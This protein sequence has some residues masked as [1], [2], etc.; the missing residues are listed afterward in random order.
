MVVTAIGLALAL[1]ATGCRGDDKAAAK[2]TWKVDGRPSAVAVARGTVW[3]ADDGDDVVRRYDAEDG[4]T[5]GRAIPVPANPVAIAAR[6]DDAWVASAG[7]EVTHLRG[8]AV[9]GSP[10]RVGGSLVGIAIAPDGV[11]LAD[12]A[13]AAVLR[14]DPASLAVT[15]TVPVPAGAVRVAAAGD[16]LW[17]TNTENTVT[18]VDRADRPDRRADRGRRRAHRAGR[19]S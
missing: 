15:A 16:V 8:G 4:D 12:I 2:N 1:V 9:A 7:G 11:W 14:V 17:V 5:I 3:V 18:R 6:G 10:A 19:R 13:N